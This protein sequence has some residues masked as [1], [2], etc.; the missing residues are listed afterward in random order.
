MDELL[1][2]RRQLARPLVRF[3]AALATLTADFESAAWDEGFAREVD[4]F[5]REQ[6][7]PAV[8]DVQ[9]ALDELG[10]RPTLLRLASSE[11]VAA[12]VA[13]LGLAAAAAVAYGDLP[14]VVYGSS[15]APVL[16]AG[17]TEA[18]HRRDAKRSAAQNSFYFLYAAER[19]L[20]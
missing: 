19:Q 16:A 13:G 12:V 5:Y 14:T 17:T 20:A 4:D 2:V 6:V 18:L 7:A 11:R 9:E 3:R 1:D 8:L 15:G 10:A